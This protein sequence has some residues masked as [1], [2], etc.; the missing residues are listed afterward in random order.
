MNQRIAVVEKIMNA[1][2]RLAAE[3][4]QRLD[5][6]GV[7]ALNL[8]A[9]PGAGKTS[10]IEKTIEKLA[11]RLR[12][13]VIDGD[14]ATSLDADRAAAAGATAVQIN[15]G[16]ECHLDAVMLQAALPQLDLDSIDLLIV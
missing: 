16:G 15:T 1:N 3:N 7:F 14:I 4:R 12:L 10:L 11:G 2:D 6:A 5:E 9:S 8:M 13:A